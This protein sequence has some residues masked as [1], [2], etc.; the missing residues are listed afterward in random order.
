MIS[1]GI[2]RFLGMTLTSLVPVQ[3]HIH[4]GPGLPGQVKLLNGEPFYTLQEA[5]VIG[6]VGANT[7]IRNDRIARWVS[8]TRPRDSYLP[9]VQRVGVKE[10]EPWPNNWG[11][12]KYREI[13]DA[14]ALSFALGCRW[15]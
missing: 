9:A 3:S 1:S 8:A 6:N 5:R 2:Y 11:V 4:P 10:P 14:L 12:V 7:T 13:P 15:A